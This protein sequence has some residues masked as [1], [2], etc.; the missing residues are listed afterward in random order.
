[1]PLLLAY[2]KNRF[3]HDV[4]RVMIQS[5]EYL[6]DHLLDNTKDTFLVKL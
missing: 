2:G 4:A 6:K 3:S 1:M 5:E